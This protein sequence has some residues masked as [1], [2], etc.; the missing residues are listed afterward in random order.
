MRF[1]VKIFSMYKKKR[2]SVIKTYNF[3]VRNFRG[4]I[5]A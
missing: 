5:N 3:C 1:K 4:M 2:N